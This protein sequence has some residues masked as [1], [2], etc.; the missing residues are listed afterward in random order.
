MD[1][2]NRMFN[3]GSH[4]FSL[5]IDHLIGA[6]IC[7]AHQRET[8]EYFSVT[9]ENLPSKDLYAHERSVA[10]ALQSVIDDEHRYFSIAMALADTFG[11]EDYY[12]DTSSI[13]SAL[14]HQ[15]KK[16][17]RLH[18]PDSVRD[19][20][21]TRF[22]GALN[23]IG[24]SNTD[25][26]GNV[27]ADHY[28]I[29]RSGFSDALAIIFNKHMEFR[30]LCQGHSSGLQR[31]SLTVESGNTN[32]NVVEEKTRDGSLWE[33]DY[34][35]DHILRLN[36]EHPFYGRMAEDGTARA[37]ALAELLYGFCEFENSQFSDSQRKLLENMRQE[38][39]RELWIKFD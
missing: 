8:C 3:E 13:A 22:P 26:F 35:E 25:M 7:F 33:P 30:L 10:S 36:P 9:F 5:Y 21:N 29:Y 28:D 34:G 17:A 24:S 15:G 2:F 4:F 6:L 14:C 16:Y 27:I 39:S 20:I 38:V 37:T 12:L 32:I 18:C 11:L 19:I 23:I 1:L 31:V